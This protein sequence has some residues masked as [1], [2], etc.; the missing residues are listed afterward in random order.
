[1]K[2][3][4]FIVAVAMSL[5]LVTGCAT[6]KIYSDPELKKETG[7]RYYTLKP[8]LLVEYQ[9][10]KDNVVKT[11]VVYLPDLTAPQYMFLKP[12]IGSSDVKMGFSNSALQSYG[13]VTDSQLP[14]S[15]EAFAAMLSKSA[16]ATQAFTRQE[17]GADGPVFKL[18][19]IIY[20]QDGTTLKEVSVL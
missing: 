6:V 17:E 7:L 2:R 19:E 4:S 8:Y 11:T 16:Y 10:D 1:M 12:G 20:G 5:L 18:Y 9:A 13:V 3:L 15:F 14:E